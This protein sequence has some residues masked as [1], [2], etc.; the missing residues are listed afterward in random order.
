MCKVCTEAVHCVAL[1][2][3]T[4]SQAFQDVASQKSLKW[5]GFETVLCDRLRALPKQEVQELFSRLAEKDRDSDS[6]VV[7]SATWDK[8]TQEPMFRTS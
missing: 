6:L 5:Q 4:L 8:I 7:S 1:L 2:T 3:R